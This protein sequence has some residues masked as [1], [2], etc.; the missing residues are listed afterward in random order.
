[1]LEK[2]QQILIDKGELYL[3][4]KVRPGAPKTE[5]KAVM[6]DETIKIDVAAAPE[7]GR[8]NEE[9]IGFLAKELGVGK[10]GVKVLSGAADRLKLIKIIKL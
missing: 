9:L 8:A 3:R 10:K 6:D 4:V 5:F 1:M 7:N 2:Y